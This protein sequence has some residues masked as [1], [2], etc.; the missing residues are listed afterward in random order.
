MKFGS[1]LC[2]ALLA[3]G[4]ST[5]FAQ[6]AWLP[7]QKQLLLTPGFSYSSFGEFWVGRDKVDNPPSGTG[8]SLDQYYAYVFA[9]YGLFPNLALDATVGYTWTESEDFGDV[10]DDG[11]ADTFLGVRYRL[12]D[13]FAAESPYLPSVAIR[14][15]GIIAGTYEEN[16]PFSPGDGAHGLEGSLLL[17]R[18]IGDTGFGLYGD[19]GYRLRDAIPDDLFGSAGIYQ[20]LGPVTL[21]FEYRHVQS[22]SGSDIGDP[23]FTFPGLKEIT[24]IVQGGIAYNDRGGRSYQFT[25]AGSVDGRNTGDKLILGVN[26]TIPFGAR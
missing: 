24:Q 4:T 13:E 19:I 21:N 10:S 6:S 16:T 9:D 3:T 23:G 12:I 14:V 7:N 25:L 20:Q 18:A 26:V 15:G 22:L 17:A 2:S 11:L 5:I 1:A 8:E